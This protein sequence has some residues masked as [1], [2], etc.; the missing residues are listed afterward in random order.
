MKWVK[1]TE[2]DKKKQAQRAAKELQKRGF[3]T[4]IKKHQ[5]RSFNRQPSNYTLMRSLGKRKR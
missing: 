4:Q 1:M 2:F 3:A 5:T